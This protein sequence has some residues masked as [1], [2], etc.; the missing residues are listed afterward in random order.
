MIQDINH[1]LN[2]IVTDDNPLDFA[3]EIAI[4]IAREEIK[5]EDDQKESPEKRIERLLERLTTRLAS[6]ALAVPTE[7]EMEAIASADGVD[8]TVYDP[9]AFTEADFHIDYMV[10]RILVEGQPCVIAGPSKSLKTS[11]S[12]DLAV[13]LA[14]GSAFLGAFAVTQPKR[15]LFLSAESGLGVIRCTASRIARARFCSLAEIPIHWGGWVPKVK[16]S[17]QLA[18]LRAAITRSEAEVVFIDPVYQAVDGTDAANV[19][20]MGQQ[21]GDICRQ[22]QHFGATP[23]LVHHST[24]TSARILAR[25]PMELSDLAGAGVTEFFRQWLLLNRRDAFDPT[26]PHRLWLSAGGSAGHASHHALDIDEDRDEDGPHGWSVTLQTAEEARQETAEAAE[27]RREAAKAA[28]EARTQAKHVE[29]VKEAFHGNLNDGLT[30][31]AIRER[32]GLNSANAGRAIGQL[33]REGWLEACQVEKS[34]RKYDGFRRTNEQ[35]D[36]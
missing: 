11:T 3:P 26:G 19:S 33:L 14:S 35:R 12:I 36:K 16:F 15:V 1:M 32:A 31:K 4:R 5:R 22:I 18:M 17:R 28:R 7:E 23:I 21:L 20:L 13:S 29:S 34:G 30:E 24:K 2:Q 25:E 27:E 10:D 6:D 8:F 9:Q